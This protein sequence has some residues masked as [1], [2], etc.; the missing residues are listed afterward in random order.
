MPD[1]AIKISNQSET[2][3]RT[4]FENTGTAT[5]LIEEDTTIVM[6]NSEF[7]K[8]SGFGKNEIEGISSWQKFI[9]E[10]DLA[11]MTEYH[12]TRRKDSSLAPGITSAN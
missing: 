2:T 9:A 7:E 6:V 1:P 3:Y 4:I 5:I 8:L 11:R 10:D 12:H